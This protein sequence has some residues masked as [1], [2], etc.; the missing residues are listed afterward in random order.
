MKSN[1]GGQTEKPIHAEKHCMRSSNLRKAHQSVH[2][3]LVMYFIAS[4]MVA[5]LFDIL[6]V[7]ARF[8]H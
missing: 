4:A 1:P 3:H 5:L 7:H 8:A 2:A 6:S